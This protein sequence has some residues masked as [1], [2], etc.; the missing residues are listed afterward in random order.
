MVRNRSLWSLISLFDPYSNVPIFLLLIMFLDSVFLSHLTR[1]KNCF[2]F[3]KFLSFDA[4]DQIALSRPNSLI[5]VKIFRLYFGT[6]IHKLNVI[7]LKQIQFPIIAIGIL[8]KCRIVDI[9]LTTWETFYRLS[10]SQRVDSL[11]HFFLYFILI[12]NELIFKGFQ[13]FIQNFNITSNVFIELILLPKDLIELFLVPSHFWLNQN[14]LSINF[15]NLLILLISCVSDNL[16][17]LF[18]LKVVGS[19]LILID[20][21]LVHIIEELVFVK[22]LI[23]LIFV[24]IL[25]DLAVYVYLQLCYL[26]LDFWHFVKFF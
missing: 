19:D 21:I 18:D 2:S 25:I 7:I 3:F 5:F 4:L 26:F 22:L 15:I 14:Q 11:V 24:G 9:L 1:I 8:L 16:V 13:I 12:F 20:K 6:Q 10:R 17:D 23:N